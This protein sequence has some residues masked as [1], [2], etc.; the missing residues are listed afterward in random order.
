VGC[1]TS[2]PNAPAEASSSKGGRGAAAEFV[3]ARRCVVENQQGCV[4][5]GLR[6]YRPFAPCWLGVGEG[7]LASG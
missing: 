7:E 3:V 6:V 2:A 4:A 5:A 1:L